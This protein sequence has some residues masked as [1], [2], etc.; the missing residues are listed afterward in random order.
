MISKR[1]GANLFASFLLC[2]V[3]DA[4]TRPLIS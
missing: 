4:M 3:T 2:K 1:D